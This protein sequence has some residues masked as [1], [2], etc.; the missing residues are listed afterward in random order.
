MWNANLIACC[1]G[2]ESH[3]MAPIKIEYLEQ[4]SFIPIS[5][6]AEET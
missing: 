1:N 6:Y 3:S 5:Y 4:N 2:R